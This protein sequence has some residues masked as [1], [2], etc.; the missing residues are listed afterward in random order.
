MF[1]SLLVI[2]V[3]LVVLFLVKLKYDN[4]KLSFKGVFYHKHCR[5]S[6]FLLHKWTAIE[7]PFQPTFWATNGHIQTLLFLLWP[8]P[9]VKVRREYLR[10]EDQ[11]VLALDWFT[12]NEQLL[13]SSSPV[14]II[15]P[16]LTCSVNE[17]S[18]LYS[19]AQD[20]SFR[21][22]VFNR[23]GHGGSVLTTASLHNSCEGKDLDEAILYIHNIYPYAKLVA[24]AYSLG[25]ALLLSYLEETKKAPLSGAVCISPSYEMDKGLDISLPPLY[26]Y[27]LTR[28]L[29]R[30][31]KQ[32]PGL[33]SVIDYD[34]ALQSC[35]VREFNERVYEPLSRFN[36]YRCGLEDPLNNNFNNISRIRVPTLCISAL[37]D[38]ICNEESIPY[39]LFKNSSNFYLIT[40]EKGGHS[41][42]FQGDVYLHSW[43]DHLASTFLDAMIHFNL[44]K[45]VESSSPMMFPHFTRD[46]SYTQ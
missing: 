36:G 25:A 11:G 38:P 13:D 44:R 30:L 17:V 21:Y 35:S 45:P 28:R 22:V 42:F 1:F 20:V 2:I 23:R 24:V 18:M 7:E 10:L 8:R 46:R 12:S 43:A 15:I 6:Q 5:L 9:E 29:L 31:L 34:L 27:L 3:V 16:G 33:S 40:C 14:L 4:Q 39:T 41:G 26:E 32:H 37:D 19:R